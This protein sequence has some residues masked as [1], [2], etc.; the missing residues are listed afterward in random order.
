[1]WRTKRGPRANHSRTRGDSVSS[2]TR[3]TGPDSY[4]SQRQTTHSD[5]LRASMPRS[6]TSEHYGTSSAA[7]RPRNVTSPGCRYGDTA[8]PFKQGHAPILEAVEASLAQIIG[9]RVFERAPFVR[10]SVAFPPRGHEGRLSPL[11]DR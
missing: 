1:L 6:P 7:L 10:R 11:G 5:S 2:S 4:R 3:R 8:N 9:A